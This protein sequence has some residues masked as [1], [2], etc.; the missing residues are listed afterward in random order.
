MINAPKLWIEKS[1]P[2]K[3]KVHVDK[4][5]HRAM[6]ELER[7][8]LIST[9]KEH[10]VSKLPRR[11]RK[12][13]SSLEAQ[14]LWPGTVFGMYGPSMSTFSSSRLFLQ[15]RLLANR[16]RSMFALRG[17]TQRSVAASFLLQSGVSLLMHRVLGDF[18]QSWTTFRSTRTGSRAWHLLMRMASPHK[19]LYVSQASFVR[20][21]QFGS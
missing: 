8:E 16:V 19:V 12:I 21:I 4:E 5:L 3:A 9:I 13:L 1:T 11:S 18:S 2:W 10:D 20:S 14:S 6:D 17:G 7:L 15:L